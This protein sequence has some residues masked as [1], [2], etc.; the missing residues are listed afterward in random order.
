M[1]LLRYLRYVLAHKWWVLVAGMRT[2]APMW[3]LLIH[4]WSKFLP[5]E[6]GPYAVYFYGGDDGPMRSPQSADRFEVAWLK[7]VHRNDHHWQHWVTTRP[8]GTASAAVMPRAA[9]LEMLADWLGAGR[10]QTGKW[11]AT[12]WY[13]RNRNQMRLHPFTR[14]IVESVL[15]RLEESGRIRALLKTRTVSRKFRT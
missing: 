6:F 9:V 11:D 10:A 3:R 14:V 5:S 2:K 8:D 1:H 4:D 12:E 7:H 15:L 13:L